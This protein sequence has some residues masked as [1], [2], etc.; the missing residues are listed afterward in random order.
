MSLLF[1]VGLLSSFSLAC[2]FPVSTLDLLSELLR[3]QHDPAAATLARSTLPCVN[4]PLTPANAAFFHRVMAEESQR[5][6][7]EHEALSSARSAVAADP[8]WTAPESSAALYA[9]AREA[10]QDVAIA[11]GDAI[12][13]DGVAGAGLHADRPAIVQTASEAGFITR[14]LVPGVAVPVATAPKSS[15]I[16]TG[17][18]ATAPLATSFPATR[19]EP[20]PP[21]VQAAPKKR[22]AAPIWVATGAATAI[23]ITAAVLANVWAAEFYDLDNPNVPGPRALTALGNR[24]NTASWVA[25]GAGIAGGTLG[26]VGVLTV[27]LP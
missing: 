24:A 1:L 5:L 15:P 12:W 4:E 21:A 14:Y 27:A 2:E 17:P 3:A 16:E 6:G 22:S 18:V 19:P 9:Q 8:T 7:R 11:L 25:L 23:S 13:I 10:G 26:A 20:L